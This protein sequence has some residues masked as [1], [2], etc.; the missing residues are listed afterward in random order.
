[1]NAR[2]A[3]TIQRRNT[4][5]IGHNY[6][7]STVENKLKE[8]PGI[9]QLNMG[10]YNYENK[11]VNSQFKLT[12]PPESLPY[13]RSLKLDYAK[14][15]LYN[16]MKLLQ[17]A[18]PSLKTLSL[19]KFQITQI[20]ALPPTTVKL[21]KLVSLNISE[22]NLSLEAL[23][24]ILKMAPNLQN[25]IVDKASPEF[26]YGLSF[27]Y[28]DLLTHSNHTFAMK[29]LADI[30]LEGEV[31]RENMFIAPDLE[32]AQSLY[33]SLGMHQQACIAAT[34]IRQSTLKIDN[35]SLG[36]IQDILSSPRGLSFTRLSLPGFNR[37]RREVD[38]RFR[39]KL[40]KHSL[41]KFEILDFQD[42]LF[43]VH[44]IFSLLNTSPN[45]KRL[46]L[47]GFELLEKNASRDP[48]QT[49]PELPV[50]NELLVIMIDGAKISPEFLKALLRASPNLCSLSYYSGNADLFS[51]VFKV[52][53]ELAKENHY[54]SMLQLASIFEIGHL[55]VQQNLQAAKSLYKKIGWEEKVTQI[56]K[57]IQNNIAFDP[58]HQFTFFGSF[59][60]AGEKRN[61]NDTQAE[62]KRL[63]IAN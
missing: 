35:T 38:N 42:S 15:T 33:T 54:F 40:E 32:L 14:L 58:I 53:S 22:S 7:L 56:K 20:E 26:R 13:L 6:N 4:V 17:A 49:L 8:A 25:L 60:S 18:A 61:A 34:M 19:E 43:S 41:G 50:F 31:F 27:I 24:T 1:M 29:K 63:K 28:M 51:L 52:Y 12:L 45:L 23:H 59:Q 55:H 44:N 9:M 3:V 10:S 11:P 46:N 5:I 30:Y 21:D 48:S 39:L 16:L 62:P 37:P 2:F 36:F 47:N 57:A